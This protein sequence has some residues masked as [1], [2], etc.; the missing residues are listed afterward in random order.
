M[1]RGDSEY[2]KC[3]LSLNTKKLWILFKIFQGP[4]NKYEEKFRG[5]GPWT[6]L[7]ASVPG[8]WKLVV[9]NFLLRV[10]K[11]ITAERWVV[12]TGW[13]PLCL[14]LCTS[15]GAGKSSGTGNFGSNPAILVARDSLYSVVGSPWVQEK[16]D[17]ALILA[18]HLPALWP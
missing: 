11:L 4:D 18:L 13:T 17:L 2:L 7:L 9:G 1:G 5:W 15:P 10:C 6:Y 14:H 16:T 8:E 3:T 12:L